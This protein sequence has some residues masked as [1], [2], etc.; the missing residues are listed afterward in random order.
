MKRVKQISLDIIVYDDELDD[1]EKLATLIEEHLNSNFHV[2]G[3]QFIEDM[4]DYYNKNYPD[5]MK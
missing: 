3:V 4:T 5:L 1:G 2:I